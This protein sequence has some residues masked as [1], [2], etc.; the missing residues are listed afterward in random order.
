MNKTGRPFRG[1]HAGNTLYPTLIQNKLALGT[2]SE[3]NNDETQSSK[4]PDN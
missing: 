2:F 1:D 4:H 3:T